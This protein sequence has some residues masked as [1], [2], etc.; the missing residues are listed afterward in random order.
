[1]SI[2][3]LGAGSWGTAIALLL[4]KNGHDVTLWSR[5]E[6][7]VQAIKA[8]GE[9]KDFLPGVGVPKDLPITCSIEEAVTGAHLVVISVPSQAVREVARLAAPLVGKKTIIVNAAKGL[10][11]STLLRLSQV[12][13]EEMPENPVAVLSGP[14]HA[15]EVARELPTTVVVASKS[16]AAAK[17]VQNTFMSRFFRVYTNEDLV[18][19]ELAGALKN[20]IALAAGMSDGLGCGDNAKAALITR[21]LAEI[22]RLGLSMGAKQQTFAGLA[23]LGD[24]V[25]TCNS[26][27][28][29]NWQAG[30]KLGQGK[31]LREVL[32]ESKMV[33]EGVSAI[34]AALALAKKNGIDMPIS[35]ILY[36]IIFEDMPTDRAMFSLMERGKTT[37]M[38]AHN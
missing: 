7:Q 30:Y 9:N 21:G 34:A 13:E 33:V 28:S 17:E 3:V 32:A 20:I 2:A 6:A 24:L 35:Q 22:S 8:A 11:Q 14:S 10:E 27:L 12:I 29:R 19:V 18:G 16:M 26:H 37:E 15:E 23:G 25:V 36:E 1:M 31:K 38:H 5:K 4:C